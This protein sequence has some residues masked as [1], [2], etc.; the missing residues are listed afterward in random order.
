MKT[1]GPWTLW[2]TNSDSK[3]H[4]NSVRRPTESIYF[5]R[6]CFA[7]SKRHGDLC[8]HSIFASEFGDLGACGLSERTAACRPDWR[9]CDA[10]R[11]HQPWI[12]KSL[13]TELKD[14]TGQVRRHL[15]PTTAPD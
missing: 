15:Y 14:N 8:E 3:R 9:I 11:H 10:K 2:V 7:A 4:S 1:V 6:L 5:R 13:G 12:T